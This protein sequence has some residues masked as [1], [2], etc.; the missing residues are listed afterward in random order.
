MFSCFQLTAPP[1]PQ[2]P[3]AFLRPGVKTATG[4]S[5]E[6]WLEPHWW[7]APGLKGSP[8]E[9]GEPHPPSQ[10]P[11]TRPQGLALT[12]FHNSRVGEK[13]P[14]PR[15][16]WGRPQ[17]PL[18]RKS[19]GRGAEYRP[20]PL[21]LTH[22]SPLKKKKTKKSVP[23]FRTLR[24]ERPMGSPQ[25]LSSCPPERNYYDLGLCSQEG[26]SLHIKVRTGDQGQNT[27]SFA[28]NTHGAPLPLTP[29]PCSLGLGS[30]HSQRPGFPRAQFSH[31]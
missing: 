25:P 5:W 3:S 14:H 24:L 1:P 17:R 30:P 12:P 10:G 11:P 6:G 20:V 21:G 26:R 16:G 13:T 4:E 27:V 29:T 31:L 7:L 2:Q 28:Q 19:A 22:A 18:G 9:P 15:E 8:Q 23:I